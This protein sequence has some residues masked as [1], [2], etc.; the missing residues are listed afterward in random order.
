MRILGSVKS[1]EEDSPSNGACLGG[2]SCLSFPRP[3]GIHT[4]PV[5]AVEALEGS[6]GSFLDY[7]CFVKPSPWILLCE[8]ACWLVYCHKASFSVDFSIQLGKIKYHSS[9]SMTG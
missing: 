6:D 8:A 3:N 2:A 7:F 4:A 5:L 1:G 9:T